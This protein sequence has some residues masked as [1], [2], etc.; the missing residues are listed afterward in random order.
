MTRKLTILICAGILSASISALCA[1]SNPQST[2][3]RFVA[4]WNAHDMKAFGSLF[5]SD[6]I[7]VPVANQMD[8]G[9]AQ[10]LKDLGEA[11]RTWASATSVRH[12][13]VRVQMLRKDV[14]TLFFHAEFLVDGKVVPD[15]ERAIILVVTKEKSGW[16]IASGQLTKQHE[17][18]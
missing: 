1:P 14:A 9:R 7:W 17:G 13:A 2:A 16:Q 11:H 15:V 12:T 18:A 4:A 8:V 3:D 6:A 10:I 5:K